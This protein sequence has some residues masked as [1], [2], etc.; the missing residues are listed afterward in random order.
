MSIRE[1]A[2]RLGLGRLALKLWHQPLARLRDS[3]RDGGPLVARGTERRRQEMEAAAF[4][5]PPL[6]PRAGAPSVTLHLLTGRRFWSQTAFCLHSFAQQAEAGVRAEIYDDGSLDDT[7][8]RQ[9]ARFGPSF[10][11]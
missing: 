6:P 9:L 7:L 3:W 1:D 2:Q 8:G 11:R 4:A 10:S 5:L